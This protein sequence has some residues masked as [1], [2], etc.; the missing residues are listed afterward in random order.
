MNER[1]C[2]GLNSVRRI[3]ERNVFSL[4]T[5]CTSGMT[6]CFTFESE[7]IIS[8]IKILCWGT[9]SSPPQFFLTLW[10]L[11]TNFE[12]SIFDEMPAVLR[13]LRLGVRPKISAATRSIITTYFSH[14]GKLKF[15]RFRYFSNPNKWKH[16]Y[17]CI[18]IF[19]SQLEF[20][21]ETQNNISNH[22]SIIVL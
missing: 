9:I 3:I 13:M 7:N 8:H 2:I 22:W 5:F 12:I 17:D 21:L 11:R 15:I 10:F 14:R 19:R 4:R 20:G 18:N 1:L 16:V 6:S